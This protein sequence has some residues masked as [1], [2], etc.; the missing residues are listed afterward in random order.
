[1]PKTKQRYSPVSAAALAEMNSYFDQRLKHGPLAVVMNIGMERWQRNDAAWFRKNS[2]RNYRLRQAIE[3]EWPVPLDATSRILVRQYEKGHR[4]RIT[5]SS[6][7]PNPG[8]FLDNLG[9]SDTA[10]EAA[11]QALAEDPNATV[12]LEMIADRAART[13]I[14]KAKKGGKQ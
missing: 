14:S 5:V 8:A 6:N 10:L 9:H 13:K 7:A 4:G 12:T 2:A 3:G 1:M 11:W